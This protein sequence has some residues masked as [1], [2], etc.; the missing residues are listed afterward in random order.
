MLPHSMQ[1]QRL[2]HTAHLNATEHVSVPL[3]TCNTYCRISADMKNQNSKELSY[4]F[5]Q[6]LK[7][8]PH[9]TAT[10]H[11]PDSNDTI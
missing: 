2:T 3:T 9:I 10:Q 4:N 5:I 1:L 7:L 11:S 8:N 6:Q